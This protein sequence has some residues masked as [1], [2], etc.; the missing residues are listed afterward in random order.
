MS[1]TPA[2]EVVTARWDRLKQSLQEFRASVGNPSY[3]QIAERVAEARRVRGVDPHSAKVARSTVF[4]LFKLGKPRVNL[5][6]VREVGSALGATEEQVEGWI[7][8]CHAQPENEKADETPAGDAVASSQH[9]ASSAVLAVAVAC[10]VLNLF[11]RM[12]TDWLHV[13][14]Y[15]DMVGTALAAF[16][17]GPWRGAA[18]G[19]AT[20]VIGWI[21]NPDAPLAFALVNVL[22]ALVWGY[23]VRRWNL[24]STLIKFFSLN[25]LVALMC[26]G[27]AV[28]LVLMHLETALKPG[29]DLLV[30]SFENLGHGLWTAV[31]FG[32]IISSVA[33]KTLSGFLALV[34]L[35]GLPAALR[36]GFSPAN[37]VMGH[38]D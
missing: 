4:D 27:V 19:F 9:P 12:F 6:L 32:N 37:Y 35:S 29:H 21:I 10:V 3:A 30:L 38:R 1:E 20:N 18:V 23:G 2:G 28:P 25:I 33:D 11:G 13:P 14:L 15:M 24:G 5:T 8:H 17:L 31:A 36:T 16:A 34:A 7:T 26:S 22:G